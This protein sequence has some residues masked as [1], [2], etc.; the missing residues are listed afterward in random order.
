[1]TNRLGLSGMKHHTSYADVAGSCYTIR[2]FRSTLPRLPSDAVNVP[3]P[4]G[5]PLDVLAEEVPRHVGGLV[6]I[7][8][9]HEVSGVE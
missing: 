2:P 3:W 7:L 1:M 8:R 4:I 5:L 9:K 6:A